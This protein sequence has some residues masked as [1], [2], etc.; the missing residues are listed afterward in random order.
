MTH[1]MQPS[2]DEYE[3]ELYNDI[4]RAVFYPMKD[5]NEFTRSN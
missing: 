4:M 3:P 1:T 5:S 2:N